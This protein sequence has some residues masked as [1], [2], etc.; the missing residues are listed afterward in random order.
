MTSVPEPRGHEPPALPRLPA[1][2]LRVLLPR[3]ER[4]EL[5]ADFA[6]EYAA[7]RGREGE[8]EARR[9]IRG[10]VVGSAPALLAWGWWREWTGFEPHA[11]RMRPGGP[12]LQSWITDA[13]YAARRLR[14]RPVYALLAVLT[15]A[16][17][18]GGTASIYG[19]A[20]GLL[21]EPLPYAN[22]ENVAV[23]WFSGSWTQEEI[24]FLRGKVPG[25][26]QLA[27]Y[28]P[29][30]L[31]SQDGDGPTRM[32][33]AIASSYE[34]FDVLGARPALGRTFRPGEDAPGAESVVVLSYGMWQEMGGKPDVIGT[35]V[36]LS[37]E[38][39]TVVG[40]MPRGF[41]F[42]DPSV[43]AWFPV[44]LNP[45]NR[46]GN[47]TLVG[48]LAPGQTMASMGGPLA[49]LTSMLGERFDYPEKWDKTKDAKLTP[50]REFLIGFV[51]PALLATLVAMGLILLIACAN[52]A[53]LMLGQLDA[54][55]TELA[56]RSALGAN[57]G[58]LIQQLLIEALLVGV[59]AAAL[60]AGLAAVGFRVLVQ[61]LPLGAW[62]ESTSLD[63]TV[64]AAAVVI[65]VGAA[66]LVAAVPVGSLWRGDLRASLGRARTGGVEGRG[67]RLESGLVVAE[68]A[69]A[70][71]IAAGA[72][73]LVRSVTKLYAIDPGVRTAGVGVVDVVASGDTNRA[74]RRQT[75]GELVTALG[76]LPGV[77]TAAAVQ[78]LPLRGSGDN[79]GVEIEGQ[80]EV[81]GQT[82]SVRVV[83]PAYFETLGIRV[84]D[85][86][87]FD[88]SDQPTGERVVV[89]NRAFAD[90]F[91]PGAN[92][93]GRRMSIG[94]D[95][96]ERIVGVIDNVAE[97]ALTDPREPAGYYL[98]DQVSY[99]ARRQSLVF[100]AERPGEETQLLE[101]ARR[102]VQRV[103]PGFAVQE[104]TT[105]DR[106]LAKAVGPA[107]QIMTLLALLSGLAVVL[108]AVGIYG[109]ISHFAN[110]RKRDWAVR[111]A[112]GLRP[113]R[114]VGHIVGR[115]ATLVG[116]GIVVGVLAAAA[117]ARLLASLLYGVSAVDPL[118]LAVASAVLLG[119]GLV[120]AFLPARRAGR[121]DP[122]LALREQ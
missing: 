105:M 3:A 19:I 84:R 16:L 66:L 8:R 54:R 52:V 51:R 15:L 121:V 113:S 4:D 49:R 99:T 26:Q 94:F 70:V 14:S 9:W 86:R 120:A 80:P 109:V 116:A 71:L 108:G 77:R 36:V 40:V 45:E 34:L 111:V 1:F 90:K 104:V 73:L 25:F 74:R 65:A 110:R 31:T 119:V 46:S 33:P 93:I 55:A 48:R 101:A 24:L 20:R 117:L 87:V 98:A 68:V 72:A 17:G 44:T 5:L 7:R 18:V 89:V 64:V 38:P 88:G 103:A 112:L 118:A 114:V 53:A 92:P 107:R 47:Y 78:K 85:G 28:R 97:G 58:R 39:L 41:W 35:R 79:W 56:V 43:R 81:Q 102:T 13:R 32:I 37:G 75:V 96:Y 50:V 106:V 82:I 76:E 27:G 57:R 10:Q 67:G 29:I 62:G 69:L 59:A 95:G 22:E 91:F 21:F 11:N 63:W 83:T 61:A 115:G 122:A 2:L 42:P 23:F 12:M 6:E 100:R 60:G 30:D